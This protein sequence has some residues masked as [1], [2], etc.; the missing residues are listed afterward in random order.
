MDFEN[1]LGQWKDPLERTIVLH[2]ATWKGHILRRHP[3]MAFLLNKVGET[4][5]K[6][7]F[8]LKQGADRLYLGEVS[9]TSYIQVVA[10]LTP[11]KSEYDGFIKTA[12]IYDEKDS[13]GEI[14]WTSI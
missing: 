5:E 6:P 10:R 7:E 13:L 4:V 12:F 1:I 8:I 11:G 14:E 9:V 2:L 3:G